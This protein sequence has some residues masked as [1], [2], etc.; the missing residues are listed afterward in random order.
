MFIKV[1]KTII[2]ML[3]EKGAK[4]AAM[5]LLTVVRSWSIWTGPMHAQGE[6]RKT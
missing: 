6:Y 3:R 2:K 4:I 1:T 5:H